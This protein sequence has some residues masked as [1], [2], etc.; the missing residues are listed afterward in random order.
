MRTLCGTFNT[1]DPGNFLHKSSFFNAPPNSLLR[2]DRGCIW[3][4]IVRPMLLILGSGET[5]KTFPTFPVT[6]PI[7]LLHWNSPPA[8]V[9]SAGFLLQHLKNSKHT[10]Q[11]TLMTSLGIMF[12]TPREHPK[13]LHNCFQPYSPWLINGP[14]CLKRVG[15]PFKDQTPG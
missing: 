4:W 6:Q 2:N 8:P 15:C 11:Q 13:T 10:L 5:P 9:C 12:S 1:E 7:T 3:I 14:S